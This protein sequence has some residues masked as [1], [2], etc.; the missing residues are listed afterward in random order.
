MSFTVDG[1]RYRRPTNTDNKKLAQA[2]LGKI[3]TKVVEEKWFDKEEQIT[4]Y[5]FDELAT[6]Y[7]TDWIPGR[8]KSDFRIH[9]IRQLK[10]RFAGYTLSMI[11][12]KELEKLQ[13]ERLKA[14]KHKRKIDGK[15]WVI[16]NKPATVNRFIAAIAHMFTK[17]ADWGMIKKADIPKVKML[18]EKNVRLRYLS[19]EECEDLIA[20]CDEYLKPIVITALNTGMRRGEILSLKWE[21]VDLKHGFILLS[22]TKNNERREIPINDTLKDL[23]KALPRRLDVPYVFYDL[24]SGKPYGEVKKSFASALRRARILDFRFHDLRNTFASHLIMAGID[25]TTVKELL[26]HKDIKMTLRYAHLA[27]SHKV[28]AVDILDKTL[29]GNFHDSFTVEA[30]RD[31]AVNATP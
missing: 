26:G 7:E 9:L 23:F 21:N 15:F 10:E 25:L 4:D 29:K 13:S 2:I 27:P 22:D 14:G 31:C 28:K 20:A 30:R 17:A 8:Y 11:T 5:S 19:L 1:K 24:S 16:P 3:N 6:Q 18:E 12:T